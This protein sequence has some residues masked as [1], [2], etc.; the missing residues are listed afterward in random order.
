MADAAQ[1][2]RQETR[3]V[4]NLVARLRELCGDDEQAFIDTLDGETEAVEAARRVV[5]WINEQDAQQTACKEL[6]GVYSGRAAVFDER[7]KRGRL[8]LFHFLTEMGLKSM[9]LPEATLSIVAGR[10]SLIGDADPALLAPELVRV[11]REPDR[12]AIKAALEAGRAVDGFSLS[13]S[14]PT[15]AMRVR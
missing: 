14:P 15:L 5:R 6:A 8:A 2:L 7:T 3:E 10:V 12:A 11:K 9:P 13:N 4:A 1:D